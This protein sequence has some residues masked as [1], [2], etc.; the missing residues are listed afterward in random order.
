M[1]SAGNGSS[2]SK[3]GRE[4]CDLGLR[5]LNS[6]RT[7]LFY[8]YCMLPQGQ[9]PVVDRVAV[10]LQ[11]QRITRHMVDE[12]S[13]KPSVVLSQRHPNRDNTRE[14]TGDVELYSGSSSSR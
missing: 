13:A 2:A 6:Q 8:G 4:D 10:V 3:I 14:L 11:R 5:Q 12:A 1:N 9:F 7:G